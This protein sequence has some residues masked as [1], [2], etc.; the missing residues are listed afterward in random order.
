M[1]IEVNSLANVLAMARNT[2][3]CILKSCIKKHRNR[4]M[5]LI[6]RYCIYASQERWQHTFD[7][8]N[9]SNWISSLDER[10]PDFKV[11]CSL[12][13]YKTLTDKTWLSKP[14]NP[15]FI[16]LKVQEHFNALLLYLTMVTFVVIKFIIHIY[17]L[18]SVGLTIKMFS[19]SFSETLFNFVE[20]IE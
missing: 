19:G 2:L 17:S 4:E 9:E 15:K 1:N 7:S 8:N 14:K 16:S 12:V 3:S 18:V 10:Y 11:F 20:F 5:L 6:Y 13:I